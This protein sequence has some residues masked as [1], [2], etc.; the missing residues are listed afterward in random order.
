MKVTKKDESLAYLDQHLSKGVFSFVNWGFSP[1]ISRTFTS[2]FQVETYFNV[3]SKSKVQWHC[4]GLPPGVKQQHSETADLLPHPPPAD[5]PREHW[6]SLGCFY[7]S[8]CQSLPMHHTRHSALQCGQARAALQS[9]HSLKHKSL[10][11][12]SEQVSI[13]KVNKMISSC[14]LSLL[15]H[16]MLQRNVHLNRFK[17]LIP[18]V[19]RQQWLIVSWVVSQDVSKDTSLREAVLMN[20]NGY[21]TN[22][23]YDCNKHYLLR[24]NMAADKSQVSETSQ[25]IWKRVLNP[26]KTHEEW[27]MKTRTHGLLVKLFI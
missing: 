24:T 7:S 20:I 18:H 9:C 1:V 14:M 3:Q 13:L 10:G 22:F 12:W 23:F 17:E 8:V 6:Q 16:N 25:P 4:Y 15:T 27:K 11:P 21:D 26:L 19:S 2:K 5:H